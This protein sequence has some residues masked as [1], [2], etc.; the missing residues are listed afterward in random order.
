VLVIVGAT[1]VAMPM[2]ALARTLGFR[3][4]VIDGRERFATRDRFP[5]ADAIHV[6]MPSELVAAQPLG[7]ATSVVLV[8]HDYKYDLPVLRTVLASEV[9]YIGLLGSARRGQAIRE[10]LASEGVSAND[11]ARVRV[12]IG[13]DIG[14]RSAAEIALSVLA[15]AIAVRESRP[16][17]PM[18][19]RERR[20]VSPRANDGE[21]AT[22]GG[23]GTDGAL[24]GQVRLTT[25]ARA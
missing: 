13:L 24:A 20:R 1:H 12:P 21:Q 16:G 7:R 18:R 23:E 25:D 3:V 4:V 22:A 11:L 2:T 15:E 9:G 5:D 8:A 19:E 6:G 17:T 10:F 14:A